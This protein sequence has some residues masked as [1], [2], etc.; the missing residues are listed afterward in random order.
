M[1]IE[2]LIGFL[3]IEDVNGLSNTDYLCMV[4][5]EKLYKIILE[6][7]KILKE[8][9]AEEYMGHVDENGHIVYAKEVTEDYFS[10][11]YYSDERILNIEDLIEKQLEKLCFSTK[12]FEKGYPS[13]IA[14]IYVQLIEHVLKIFHTEERY[15]KYFIRFEKYPVWVFGDR[16]E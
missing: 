15:K 11:K 4:I 3:N 16:L 6:K 2:E 14:T 9:K 5:A 12:D 13:E 10:G 1:N 8:K 7:D